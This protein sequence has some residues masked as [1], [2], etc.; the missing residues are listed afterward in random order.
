MADIK[1][2][3]YTRQLDTSLS[4]PV[5]ASCGIPFVVGTAPIHT[6]EDGKVN[7]P[8]LCYSYAEAVTALGYSD[9]WE[10]YTLSEFVYSQFVLY[11]VAPVVVLNVLDPDKHKKTVAATEYTVEDSQALLPLEAIKDTVVVTGYEPED[12]SLFYDGENLVLEIDQSGTIPADVGTLEITF[13]AVAPEMVEISD[14][15]GGFDVTN[16][17][18]LG[19]EAI[20]SIFGKYS[21]LVDLILAPGW[22]HHSEIAT[23]MGAKAESISGFFQGVAIVDVDDK[24]VPYYTDVPAWKKEKNIFS[25]HQILCYP[26]VKLGDRKFH[27]STHIC[28]RMGSTDTDNGGCPYESPS[29]KSLKIDSCVS[30]END[31]SMFLSVTQANYLNGNGVVTALNHIG[32]YVA[33]GNYTACYPSDTD[34]KN[35][36]IPISRMFY[37]VA[38]T[39]IMTYWSKTDK[40]MTR[41]LIDNVIDSTNMWLNGLYAEEKI[42]GGRVEFLDDENTTISLMAGTMTFHVYLTPPNPAQEIEF[43]LEYD[44]DYV[45]TALT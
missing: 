21:L 41:R 14:I 30:G 24:E 29:N 38:S 19:L 4:T 34:V 22:S 11:G 27:L 3:V 20:D 9:N 36:F 23:V 33:W 31:E 44:P 7:E 32:G 26:S 6:A 10:D 40:P 45:E 28:G 8:I 42:L 16:K 35:Y 25:K 2:G 1:H 12:Y 43:V 17:K 39:L 37:W 13:S 18:Y 5:V 15:V